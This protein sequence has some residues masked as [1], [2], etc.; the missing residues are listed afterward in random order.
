MGEKE[1]LNY[2]LLELNQ[3]SKYMLSEN[4]AIEAIELLNAISWFYI[5]KMVLL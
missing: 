4:I 5:K 3:Y 1:I 2:L